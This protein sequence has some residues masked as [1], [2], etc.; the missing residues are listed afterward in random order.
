MRYADD[1]IRILGPGKPVVGQLQLEPAGLIKYEAPVWELR[2]L[3]KLT[4]GSECP[5][6]PTWR[7][8]MVQLVSKQL[9]HAAPNLHVMGVGNCML[10]K[11][12]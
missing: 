1:E 7:F 2:L 11:W 8:A 9:P 5:G 10:W 3:I 12:A 6:P 4:L